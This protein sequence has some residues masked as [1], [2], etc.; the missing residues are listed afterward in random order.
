MSP[1]SAGGAEQIL[2]LLDRQ[3][4]ERGYESLVIASQGSI[5]QGELFPVDVPLR[6]S[7]EADRSL[8]YTRFR[9]AI[10]QV[11]RDH[12]V[13][14]VHMHGLDFY[15]YLPAIDIPILVTLHLPIS[16]YPTHVFTPRRAR[17]YFNCV[18]R[19]QLADCPQTPSVLGVV[20]NGIGAEMFAAPQKQKQSYAFALGRICPEK[21]YHL[22]AEACRLARTPLYVGGRVFP[23]AAH[24]VYFREQLLPLLGPPNRYVG[25]VKLSEKR[26]WLS[27]ARCLLIPSLVAE[28]SSLA[29]M[30]A[31]AC[32]T[33][34]V[35]FP[36]GALNEIVQPGRTGW[37][38][39]GVQQ[40][41]EYIRRSGEI[42]QSVCRA[43]AR[44][45][46]CADRMVDNYL[47][48]YERVLA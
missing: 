30:E 1:D 17:T 41:S 11:I 39:S 26:D 8:V 2:A 45:R 21:G 28:T 46:F 37:L 33:P 40:M 36:S 34:V 43:T 32:G 22:A 20:E 14:I 31:M 23:Y 12:G 15:E 42:Q 6:S 16:F 4:T 7:P 27:K 48:L 25:P 5:L 38:A 9:H 18:S 44:D 47:K 29:A 24:E 13:E 10:Q 19:C 3:L 35:A